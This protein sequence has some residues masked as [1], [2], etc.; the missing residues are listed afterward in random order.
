MANRDIKRCSTWLVIRGM[1]IKTTMMYHL[2]PV[3][4]VVVNENTDTNVSKDVE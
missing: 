2:T 3:R 1:Q 4:M